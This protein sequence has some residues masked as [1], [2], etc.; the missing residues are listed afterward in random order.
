MER[1]EGEK[2]QHMSIPLVGKLRGRGHSSTMHKKE[3]DS[4]LGDRIT[5][6]WTNAAVE[7]HRKPG[8]ASRVMG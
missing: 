8:H 5:Q 4:N 3:T 6:R 1:S 7:E 2:Q